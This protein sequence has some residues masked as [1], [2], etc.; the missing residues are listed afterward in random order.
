M[1]KIIRILSLGMLTLLTAGAM[2]GVP[3]ILQGQD[4]NF[5]VDSK[6]KGKALEAAVQKLNA[7]QIRNLKQH[8]IEI[9]EREPFDSNSLKNIILLSSL[10]SDKKLQ[11]Q[12]ALQ[13]SKF[14]KR[15]IAAQIKTIDILLT[16]KQFRKALLEADALLRARPQMT[17]VILPAFMALTADK[18]GLIALANTLNENPPW[19]AELI[20]LLIKADREQ[21][22][23]LALLNALRQIKSVPKTEELVW[24]ITAL[25]TDKKYDKA[26]FV[27]LDSLQQEE[28]RYVGRI[29]D[30]GFDREPKN[31]FFDWTILPRQNARISIVLRPGAVNNR[32]LA[33]DF[34]GDKGYFNNIFQYLQ[35]FPGKYEIS[36]EFMAQGLRTE[37]GLVWES[38][39]IEGGSLG[40]SQKIQK[41]GSWQTLTFSID[42]PEVGCGTQ[43]LILQSASAAQLDTQ[44]SGQVYFDTIQIIPYA[45]S[46]NEVPN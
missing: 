42:V 29:F 5:I 2:F 12:L 10:G 27:W 37:Q 38:R 36:F 35:I 33:V 19:R 46:K 28:L 4:S 39:C 32:A 11:E 41:S 24:I 20:L 9:L 3:D 26:Y 43:V 25:I 21:N 13:I 23:A 6:F 18:N 34:Y 22:A 30:G 31:S 1:Y 17:K 7:G 45:P 40:R 14:S 15:N 16:R 44:I 8:N